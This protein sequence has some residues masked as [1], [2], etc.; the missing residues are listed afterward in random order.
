MAAVAPKTP[1]ARF[2]EKKRPD[3]LNF[4]GPVTHLG[5]L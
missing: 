2:S 1:G 5:V 4:I 3:I